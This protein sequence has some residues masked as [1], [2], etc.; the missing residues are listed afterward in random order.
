[1]RMDYTI[2]RN[3]L[4]KV[5]LLPKEFPHDMERQ[6]QQYPDDSPSSSRFPYSA[7]MK[8]GIFA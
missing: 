6:Q 2:L 1:M 7:C 8:S 4:L 5:L 3:S